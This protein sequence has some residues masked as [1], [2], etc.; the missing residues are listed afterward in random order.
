M[1]M[2]Q[3]A[4]AIETG[5]NINKHDLSRPILE[6]TNVSVRFNGTLALNNITFELQ[7]GERVAIIGPNGA[8][9]STLLNVIAGILPPAQGRVTVYGHAPHKHICIAYVPQRNE[10]DWDFPVNVADVVMMGRVGKMGLFKWPT[11]K[12]WNHVYEALALVNMSHLAKRQIGEL[13]GGQQQ[14][15]FIARA[16][17][18]EA[19]LMLMDEPLSGLDVKSQ[20]DIFEILEKLRQHGVT[21]MVATHDLNLAAEQF[22]RLMLVNQTLIGFGTASQ[23]F[24]TDLLSQAYSGSMRL[25]ETPNGTIFISDTCCGGGEET[26]GG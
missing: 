17:A 25:I 1:E 4:P 26:P 13:S 8:G 24:T 15:V 9:K 3:T 18:Q 21:V 11:R 7:Q 10:V 16:L 2:V 19:E 12:D 14:R 20:E 5:E 6:V 22:D 23:V